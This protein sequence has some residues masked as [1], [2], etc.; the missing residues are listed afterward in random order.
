MRSSQMEMDRRKSKRHSGDSASLQKVGEKKSSRADRRNG[1][2]RKRISKAHNERQKSL[3]VSDEK[4]NKA[5][6]A[7]AMMLDIG[8]IIPY[9]RN[10]RTHPEKQIT[11][12][13]QLIKKYG[14]DQPIVVDEN[15]IILK[16]H[17]RRLAA[18]E[19]GIKTFPV[20]RHIGLS[21]K[22]KKAIRIADNQVALLAGWDDELLRLEVVELQSQGFD[23]PMLGFPQDQLI[24]IFGDEAP[25]IDRELSA[26]ERVFLNTAWTLCVADWARIIDGF[27]DGGFLSGQFTKGSLAVYFARA[28]L[29]GD[30]IP[31]G[32]T[33][34]YTGHRLFVNGDTQG[35]LSDFIHH[36][37]DP[38]PDKTPSIESVRW[39]CGERPLL[40]KFLNTTLAFCGHRQPAEF[41]VILARQLIDEFCTKPGARVLDPC[42]GW[43]G[44]ALGYLLSE[45]ATFY[46]GFDVD[47][48][49]R[50]GV[51]QMIV[52]LMP[53]Y[54][55]KRADLT[56][57]PY[58]DA[59][60]GKSEYD[61]AITSPPYFDTEKYNGE[62]SSWR[63]Y[64]EF[65]SWVEGFFTPLIVKTAAALKPNAVFALQVGNQRHPLED[66]A[67]KIVA[68]CG[69]GLIEKRHTDMINNYTGT[70]ADDGEI[71]M[72]LQKGARG[73][74][75]AP[76][77][78]VEIKV[79]AKMAR[80]E[81]TECGPACIEQNG[82]KGNCCKSPGKPGG[83]FV[84]V[85]PDEQ[86]YVEKA[87]ATVVDGMIKVADGERGCPFQKAN[88]LCGVH[89]TKA[90]PFGCIAS[91]FTLNRKG[92]LIIRQRYTVLP[93]H[94]GPGKKEPAYK[95]FRSSLALIFGEKE[96]DRITQKL[97]SGS[98]DFSATISREIY[99]KLLSNDAVKRKHKQQD[100]KKAPGAEAGG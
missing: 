3:N 40:D 63:R 15:N 43:G 30:D 90:K 88:G 20:V 51:K 41:P 1:A 78:G 34:P 94:L 35:S 16:G 18:I 77:S 65:N 81:F 12:L 55:K 26:D 98:G 32:A 68:K 29:F 42:H 31:R 7:K 87:G 99:N 91:P 37:F 52:D 9:E 60:I 10:A 72:L 27:R 62:E 83:C 21:E 76:P 86:K 44:R 33:L 50:L 14:A 54:Q 2:D 75:S 79:S 61:F 53:F 95:V 66:I 89:G 5:L 45:S 36:D 97:D 56:L 82:C 64:P 71:V 70:E 48:Q 8:K 6:F 22:D 11:L 19:A 57:C 46:Q 80:I 24:D 73:K 17:G 93:C 58:E 13:A 25:K 38:Q 59:K 23:M 100:Q 84:T 67:I 28:K 49:T 69:M 85:H 96:T 92:T 74:I 47:P 4:R 39:F